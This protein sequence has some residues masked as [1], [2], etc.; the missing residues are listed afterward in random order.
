[1]NLKSQWL[2]GVLS[3]SR[4]TSR[5]RSRLATGRRES[6]ELLEQKLLLVGDVAGTLL[7]DANENG[8]KDNDEN[9][10]AG[11]TV[12]V[13][14]NNDGSLDADEPSA[15]TNVDG[16]YLIT[17]LADGDYV[18]REVLQPGWS[19]SPGT[20]AFQT[21]TIFDGN[22][23]KANFF[24][25]IASVGSITG[26]VWNDFNGDGIRA[27][28]DTGLSGWTIFIDVNNNSV[29]DL[30]ELSTTTDVNGDY[31]FPVVASGEHK[32]REVLPAG[33][34]TSPGYDTNKSVIVTTGGETVLDFANFTPEAG[35]VSGTVW[36]DL[37]NNHVRATD[38]TSGAYTEPG[39]A[40]WQVFVDQNGD[41]LLTLGEP[42]A[43]TDANG[44]Y[45]I[46]GVPYGLNTIREVT[47]PDFAP[48]APVSASYTFTLLNGQAVD[49]YDFGNYERHDASISG[50]IYA[51]SDHDGVRDPGERGLAGITIYLDLD[52]DDLLDDSEPRIVTSDDLYYT[53]S[54]DEA[55]TYSFTHLAKGTY[56]VREILPED[57]TPTPETEVEHA[58]TVSG[59]EDKSDVDC[60]N[61]Y[62]PNEIHG[63]KFDDL[64]ADHVRDLGEP[65]LGGVSIYIDLDRDNV[66][67]ATEPTTVTAADGSYAFKDLTPGAYVVREIVQAGYTQTYPT[68]VGGILQPAGVSNP[69]VGNVTPGSINISLADG[70]THRQ[71]VSLT[72]PDTGALTN[73]VDV[74]LL[75]DDTGSFTGNSPLVRA[76]FPEI[77]ASLQASLP[78]IDLGFGVGRLEEY[79]NFAGE[80]ATGRPFILNQ[81]I[82]AASTAGFSTSIQAALDRMAP[83]YGGDQPETDIEALYQLVTGAGF[84]G[85][86]NGSVLDSGAAGLVSTQLNP[87]SSGDVPS[88]A[89]FTA[90]ASGNVLPAAGNLGGGGFRA[91]ALPI[92][93]T[94][95]DTGFAYQPKGETSVTGVG[96]LT[97]PVSALTET[98]R[99]TTPFNYGAGL[100]ETITGLNALGALVIGIGTNP[101]ATL[102]PRQGLEALAKLTGAINQST[103]TIDNGT[104]DPI[105]P[106]DPFYFQITTGFAAS[107]ANGVTSAI[108]NAVTNVAVN[109]TVKASD[110]R[111]KIIN[112]TGTITSVGA[113]QTASFDIEFVGN[114]IPRRFDL[115]FVREGSNVVLG[116]IPVVIGTPIP[117]DG[118]EF[119]EMEDGQIVTDCDFGNTTSLVTVVAPSVSSIATAGTSPTN[120]ASVDYTVTFSEDVTDVTAD[121]FLIDATGITGAAITGVIGSGTTYTV[122]VATGTGDGTLSID[123]TGSVLDVDSNASTTTF[124]TGAA[125]TLDKTAPSAASITRAAAN[126]TN[127]ASV[128]FTV[129]FSEDVTGLALDDFAIDA[130]GVTGVVVTDVTGSGTTY[131]VTVGTGTGDGTLSIDFT[132][133]VTDSAGNES[134]ATLV[135]G[136]TYLIDKTLP[137]VTSIT[138]VGSNPTNAASVTFS[139]VFSEDVT[140]LAADDFLVDET[141]V[142]GAVVSAVSGS[143]TTYSVTVDTGS[144]DGLLSLDFLGLVTDSVGNDSATT[145]VDGESFTIDKTLPVV[146]SITRTS[147]SPTNAASVTFSVLFSE[148]VTGLT[149]DDLAIDATGIT[150]AIVTDVT[151]SGS[152]YTVTVNTGSD[153]GLLS[154]D[155]LGVVTD[156]VG[157]DSAASFMDGEA[158]S[159][160][161][162]LPT[163]TAITRAG[164]DPTNSANVTFTVTFSEDVSGLAAEDFLV[165]ESGVSG[166]VITAI[167]GSGATYLVSVDTG[168]GDGTLSL[169]FIGTVTDSIG[170]DSAASFLEG[171]AYTLDKTAP[172]ATSITP[173]ATAVNSGTTVT[174]TVVFDEAA[175]NVTADDFQLSATDTANGAIANVSGSGTTYT[176]TVDSVTGAGTLRLDLKAGTDVQDA[177]GNLS[178]EFNGGDV[179]TITQTVDVTVVLPSAG[180]AFKVFQDA[181]GLLH[182]TK[183]RIEVGG[184]T[185]PISLAL[186]NGLTIIGGSGR[187][188]VT[189]DA[190]LADFAGTLTILGN[191]GNDTLN[192][193]AVA[194]AVSLD[195]GDGNDVLIG[196][197]GV[198]SLNGGNGNDLLTGGDGNDLLLGSVGKDTIRGLAGDDE[199]DGGLGDD[200]LQGADGND[201]IHGGAGKD[202]V[203]GGN[204]DDCL[205]GDDDNDK[206]LGGDGNDT[207]RGGLGNDSMDGGL[208]DDV[209]LGEDGKDT[210]AGGLG[211]DILSG[212]LGDDS[213]NGNGG[214]VTV[215]DGNDTLLGEAGRDTLK[216]GA[217]DDVL[218]GGDDNDSLTGE[219]GN[220]SLFG[221]LGT[222]KLLQGETNSP[223]DVFNDLAFFA[224][225][226][227]LLA[228]CP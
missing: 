138:R 174:F 185:L 67:D 11:W 31:V 214:R 192:A 79:A 59:A 16:D 121:D 124:T 205:H 210:L 201:E 208:G 120:A 39:L 217:G 106:G 60:G 74:F 44:D 200:S 62:R 36:N 90:D 134:A 198:D 93:L 122:S 163:V 57:Q 8:L 66:F 202:V 111:V 182:I 162:T 105:A 7:H 88:F 179:V 71:T 153:D 206:L 110:P 80:Y 109:L 191:G 63:V 227:D 136:E 18:V 220:D 199:I 189:L 184:P 143:G 33:W 81:P 228:A 144:G 94:A 209:L 177:V 224:H 95:T 58:V 215:G 26:T 113:G 34:T 167:S 72:L 70:E 56:F 132:G 6:V 48:T 129:T 158:Y 148:D 51:D 171:E 97:L 115:Q 139:I 173:D 43:T 211:S 46:F 146:T 175:L 24:N 2:K 9:G 152:A 172:A 128:T 154:I 98:S 119:E 40:G 141:G 108:Q 20:E 160:E 226:E 118:Y 64:D 164:S 77:I 219:A 21:A 155:F 84:D 183:G 116:S 85:N 223:D 12:F 161:K 55:G 5:K 91:G 112:H 73:M 96:G 197:A 151:G 103:T 131:T 47:N 135:D 170:N 17:D 3:K 68:T 222:D 188:S 123:F 216:G 127:A 168:S 45:T 137:S 165:D 195:G 54:V 140:G 147:A 186:V 82:V 22:E 221:G 196:G 180:G 156:S 190:S 86:N 181:A 19:P 49:G 10:L 225:L 89:S 100:Q 37:D 218:D 41:G 32:V 15:V 114:G 102:D 193:S 83:G 159:I 92:I 133:L 178:G 203:D 142:T 25:T 4:Q 194:F 53:P 30:G 35:S 50:R 204:G 69:A 104:A 107:V 169:D 187:D 130:T 145:F 157:N 126:P 75:F 176:V 28:T 65:G 27:L 166:A 78:G 38:P 76:A 117:G 150:G 42:A 207:L 99:A 87:G 61:V 213:L 1:M 125:Y 101:E 13:D 14:Y 29:A 212:G 23:F 149:L 52:N